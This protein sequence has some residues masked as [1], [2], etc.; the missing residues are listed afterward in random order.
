MNATLAEGLV[1]SPPRASEESTIS[2]SKLTYPLTIVILIVS[3]AGAFYALK[4]RLDVIEVKIDAGKEV[5]AAR[6][7]T[8]AVELE[9][10]KSA[11]EALTTGLK[12]VRARQDLFN[13]QI[14]EMAKQQ[15]R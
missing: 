4:S 14:A 6:A 2:A 9:A 5:E 11:I 15:R 10:L 12:D 13:L 7:Q 1:M 3:L 8:R